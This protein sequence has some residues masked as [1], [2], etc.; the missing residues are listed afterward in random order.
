MKY[1]WMIQLNLINQRIV[2]SGL[3]GRVDHQVHTN[4]E[5]KNFKK[6]TCT[7]NINTYS[8][9]LILSFLISV[10]L[11]RQLQGDIY[12]DIIISEINKTFITEFFLRLCLFVGALLLFEY[13]HL[14]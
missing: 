5:G 9:C 14:A 13:F 10:S 12:T 7:H 1:P 4:Y 8:Q 6:I 11:A 2:F 3:W